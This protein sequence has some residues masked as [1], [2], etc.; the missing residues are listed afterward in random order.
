MMTL[1]LASGV[2]SKAQLDKDIVDVVAEQIRVLEEVPH[3]HLGG[4]VGG[5]MAARFLDH[6]APDDQIGVTGASSCRGLEPRRAPRTSFD[7]VT[8]GSLDDPFAAL[9][10]PPASPC[11]DLDCSEP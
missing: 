1:G 7:T 3:T 11:Y 5:S 8:A 6:T 2:R 9:Q 4:P 10:L